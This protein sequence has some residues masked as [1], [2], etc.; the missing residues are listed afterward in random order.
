[1]SKKP[2]AS[3]FLTCWLYFHWDWKGAEQ[4]GHFSLMAQSRLQCLL[5]RWASFR[6]FPHPR[7]QGKGNKAGLLRGRR[8]RSMNI[9]LSTLPL[10]SLFLVTL[11]IVTS[12]HHLATHVTLL[13]GRLL[14]MRL[15]VPRKILL[16]APLQALRA[17]TDL[18]SRGEVHLNN[19]CRFC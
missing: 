8:V 15:E 13:L 3:W 19:I 12:S 10:A 18:L 6:R 7:S 14:V 1:M 5:T 17:N 2:A 4:V 9:K 11:Q 16:I